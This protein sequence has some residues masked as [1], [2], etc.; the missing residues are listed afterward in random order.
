MSR[1][2]EIEA[3]MV[4]RKKLGWLTMHIDDVGWL[5]ARVRELEAALTST[6]KALEWAHDDC[7]AGY[8]KHASVLAPLR[9]LADGEGG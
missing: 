9:A 3:V 4:L 1:L 2:D 5:A 6:T 8:Y 7:W